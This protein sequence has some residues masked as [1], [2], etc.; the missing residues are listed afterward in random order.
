[1]SRPIIA[2]A[3][4]CAGHDIERHDPSHRPISGMSAAASAV[5]AR[6]VTAIVA[7]MLLMA[8]SA[9]SATVLYSTFGP[10]DSFDGHRLQYV[11]WG[12]AVGAGFENRQVANRFTVGLGAEVTSYRVAV[13]HFSVGDPGQG[14]LSLWSGSTAPTTL[15]EPDIGFDIG[16]GN[17]LI[18]TIDSLLHPVL[19]PG[20]TY[21]L[22]LAAPESPE[23][24]RWYQSDQ[25]I[26]PDWD[27]QFRDDVHGWTSAGTMASAFDINGAGASAPE[28]ATALLVGA[29]LLVA[30]LA[31]RRYR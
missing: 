19:M 9:V 25:P 17:A 4:P 1:M 30:G 13:S 28:P 12:D 6:V 29:A 5:M 15:V 24:F 23:L 14:L 27:L 10:G 26:S 16:R 2:A 21:W 20:E 11:G 31:R 3:R 7:L 18:A 22:V 8:G